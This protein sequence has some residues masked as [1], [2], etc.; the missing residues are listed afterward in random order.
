VDKKYSLVVVEGPDDQAAIGRVLRLLGFDKFNGR[1][2]NLDTFWEN[3]KPI[4]PKKGDLYKPLS[5]PH[6]YTS[7]SHSVAIFNGEGKNNIPVE[8]ATI[9]LSYGLSLHAIG[10]VLDADGQQAQRVVER[11]IQD[12]QKAA[13]QRGT[14]FPPVSGEPGKIMLGNPRTGF[15]VL[16][17]KIEAGISLDSILVECASVIYPDYMLHAGHYLDDVAQHITDSH[18]NRLKQTPHREKVLVASIVSVLKPGSG[19]A[20]SIAQDRW[21]SEQTI[22]AIPELILLKQFLIDLLELSTSESEVGSQP[23]VLS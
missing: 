20:P 15:H 22:N 8:A 9:Y 18:T 5:M 4:Y 1:D 10:L 21:I 7:R 17:S 3:L 12:L 16:P 14:V 2:E 6:I 19:N 13:Q 11:G 23:T